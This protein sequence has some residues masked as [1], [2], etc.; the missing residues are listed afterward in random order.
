MGLKELGAALLGSAF[1]LN[2]HWAISIH[3]VYGTIFC[4]SRE[5]EAELIYLIGRQCILP[6]QKLRVTLRELRV[7]HRCLN[8]HL[9]RAKPGQAADNIGDLPLTLWRKRTVLEHTVVN[10]IF[11]F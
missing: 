3:W 6:C 7:I 11:C 1:F 5:L 8:Q 9:C 4:T 2:Q 10:V